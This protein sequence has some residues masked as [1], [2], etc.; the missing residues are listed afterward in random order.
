MSLPDHDQSPTSVVQHSDRHA[1][2]EQLTPNQLKRAPSARIPGAE[3]LRGTSPP[4]VR[5]CRSACPALSVTTTQRTQLDRRTRQPDTRSARW[6]S[7]R[8]PSHRPTAIQPCESNWRRGPRN[9]RTTPMGANPPL[10]HSVEQSATDQRAE[11]YQPTTAAIPVQRLHEHGANASDGG[12]RMAD[13][14][15]RMADGGWR[16]ADGGWRMA[17]GGWRMAAASGCAGRQFVPDDCVRAVSADTS[18]SRQHYLS[19]AI[20]VTI[21]VTL[22]DGAPLTALTTQI[23][24]ATT[25]LQR[26]GQHGLGRTGLETRA[27]AGADH[28]RRRGKPCGSTRLPSALYDAPVNTMRVERLDFSSHDTCS[29]SRHNGGRATTEVRARTEVDQRL[30]ACPSGTT[31]QTIVVTT[32]GVGRYRHR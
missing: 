25:C 14:G 8:P 7:G 20:Q 32:P 29:E 28:P 31:N 3:N 5:Q 10:R 24:G 21:Q 18:P 4:R 13:G 15:W 27:L 17:D 11:V 9:P 23:G 12:W 16:M 26:R 6:P 1:P 30:Q 2:S 22:A 19:I